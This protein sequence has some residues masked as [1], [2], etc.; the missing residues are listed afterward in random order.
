MIQVRG[1][2]GGLP[3]LPLELN[4]RDEDIMLTARA[5]NGCGGCRSHAAHERMCPIYRAAPAEEASPRAKANLMRAILNGHLDGNLLKSDALKEVADLCVNCHQ[6]RL[7][8]PA[9]VDIPKL[10]L[11]CKAQ[12]V[13]NNGLTLSQAF[14]GRLDVVAS[15]ASWARPFSNWALASPGLRWLLEKTLGIAQGR[16]LPRVA[17]RSFLRQAARRR[18]NRPTRRDAHKVLYFV[19][20]YANWFDP[21]LAEALVA[22]MEHHG[23]SVFVPSDQFSSAMP[24][25]TLGAVAKARP[26]VRRNV[27]LLAEAVRQG[28]HVVA[29]EPSA[30]LALTRE[31]PQLL[32]DEDAQL[33]AHNSSEACGYLWRMHQLG[34][35]E[36]DLKPVNVTVGYHQPCHVRALQRGSPGENLL[37]LIPGISVRT[38]D[39]GCSGMAGTFGLHRDNYRTSLRIGRGLISALRHPSVQLG[40]TECSACKL[41]MEQGTTKPTIHPLKLLAIA[42]GLLPAMNGVLNSTGQE[43]IAT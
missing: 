24:L 29:T 7:E 25:I 38:I 13:S 10:M 21:Q 16:K 26:T 12:F 42:Y 41:Q 8:C 19:D 20:L 28:Y 40:V 43:R 6:C 11:E 1:D 22:I 37:R 34:Q 27:H 23:I 30:A 35:L 2:T 32:D 17:A 4:W 33:V 39:E 15:W 5:C 18:L 36:L 9:A 14:L 3:V 31:Y